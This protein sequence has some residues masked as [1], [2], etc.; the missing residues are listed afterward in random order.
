[1]DNETKNSIHS[2]VYINYF[3]F[4]LYF[5]IFMVLYWYKIKS[6]S[7]FLPTLTILTPYLL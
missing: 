6:I 4:L 1:M 5:K 3:L 2:I 7:N